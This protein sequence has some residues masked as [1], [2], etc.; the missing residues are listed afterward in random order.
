MA[1]WN[2]ACDCSK[3]ITFLTDSIITPNLNDTL[4]AG[5]P[6]KLTWK[7]D[8]DAT[9]FSASLRTQ[10][11]TC[12]VTPCCFS[13]GQ[14]NSTSTRIL[15]RVP[16]TGEATWVPSKDFPSRNDYLIDGR[17]D[18]VENGVLRST[19]VLGSSWIKLRRFEGDESF[20][21]P[22]W[23]DVQADLR[24]S[25]SA[26]RAS[27]SAAATSTTTS[28]AGTATDQAAKS[29]AIGRRE[30]H[31]SWKWRVGMLLFVMPGLL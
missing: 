28:A 3:T 10:D 23:H 24:A 16:D 9:Y 15:D 6:I 19:K 1:S 25:D 26:S 11:C 18:Y 21:L 27:T 7:S 12:Y 30:D 14:E 20:N 31:V 5:T 2:G 8:R 17:L 13:G 29:K 22:D 4:I